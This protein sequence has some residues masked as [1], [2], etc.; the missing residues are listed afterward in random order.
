MGE[1]NEETQLDLDTALY[2]L[3]EAVRYAEQGSIGGAAWRLADASEWL[4][5]AA[6]KQGIEVQGLH[7][8]TGRGNL[9]TQRPP[10]GGVE[11]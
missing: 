9:L 7:F 8:E 10:R 11:G 6:D 2:L 4:C 5:K 3:R 1:L